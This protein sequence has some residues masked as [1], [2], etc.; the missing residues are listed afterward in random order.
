MCWTGTPLFHCSEVDISVLIVDRFYDDAE[1]IRRRAL[2]LDYPVPTTEKNYPGK[3][4]VQN[5]LPEGL[6]RFNT[7]RI[8]GAGLARQ[9]LAAFPVPGE[10]PD[11]H[12]LEFFGKWARV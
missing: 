10:K 6:D 5:F 11:F 12:R 7:Y 8:H 3:N 2:E 9:Y 1:V 4:S